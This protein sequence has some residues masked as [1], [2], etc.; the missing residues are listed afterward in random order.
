[1]DALLA[2][3]ASFNLPRRTAAVRS[4]AFYD[5]ANL[6]V[7]VLNLRQDEPEMDLSILDALVHADRYDTMIGDMERSNAS[8]HSFT[9]VYA[10]GVEGFSSAGD[11]EQLATLTYNR[12]VFELVATRVRMF[13]DAY[14]KGD[15][16][17]RAGLQ[18]APR[19]DG[20]PQAMVGQRH[21]AAAVAP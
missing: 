16:L 5:P 15:E 21:L 10:F 12:D 4:T 18:Q 6:R 11:A 20:V 9:S 17:A 7:P 14:L 2:L 1:M 19:W 13:L 3:D 8:H